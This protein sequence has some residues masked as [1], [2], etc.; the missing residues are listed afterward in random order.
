MSNSS[1]IVEVSAAIRQQL[2]QAILPDQ[3]SIVELTPPREKPEKDLVSLWLYRVNRNGDVANNERMRTDAGELL[4]RPLPV[5][6]HYLI[7]PQFT[8]NKTE[9]QVLGSIMQFFH[10]YPSLQSQ[11]SEISEDI[12]LKITPELLSVKQHAHIWQAL[13]QP[14][15]L[16]VSYLVQ[17]VRIDSLLP[18]TK[19]PPI[20]KSEI[21]FS[22]IV[23][24][25]SN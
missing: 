23:A 3:P 17:C 15:R 4:H 6:L 16:S 9:Q 13:A 19:A 11:P 22:Q 10:S 20:Q 2:N 8:V 7:T 14:F 21:R 12:K 25:S 5:D 24:S 1:I 18:P